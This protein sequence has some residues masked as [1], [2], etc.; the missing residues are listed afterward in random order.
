VQQVLMEQ[1]QGVHLKVVLVE[2]PLLD[3]LLATQLKAEPLAILF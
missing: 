1:E 2:V 3:L